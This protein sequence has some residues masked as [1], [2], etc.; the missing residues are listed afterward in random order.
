V[1]SLIASCD[2][3]ISL[4]RSEGLGLGMAQSMALGKPVNATRYSGNLEFMNSENSLL[5]EYRLATVEESTEAYE[6][7]SA[8]AEPDLDHAAE[9]MRRVHERRDAAIQPGNAARESIRVPLDPEATRREIIEH[10]E[11]IRRAVPVAATARRGT[12]LAR[13]E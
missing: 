9:R 12:P 1:R 3:F 2:C 10:A 4:H 6:A 11:R 13:E 8:W 5:V 7:G